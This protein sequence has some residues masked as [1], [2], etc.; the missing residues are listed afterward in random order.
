MLKGSEVTCYL[1]LI[2]KLLV[3]RLLRKLPPNSQQS[4]ERRMFSLLEYTHTVSICA[5]Y[6]E[7]FKVDRPQCYF[8]SRN[9]LNELSLKEF[10]RVSGYD[11]NDV[12]SSFLNS[13]SANLFMLEL[14]SAILRL[15]RTCSSYRCAIINGTYNNF[16]NIRSFE[17]LISI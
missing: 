8:Y 9:V 3:N 6:R 15:N 16:M 5:I 17:E 7:E 11:L 13:G 10:E 1:N 2:P 4:I 12:L 14:I